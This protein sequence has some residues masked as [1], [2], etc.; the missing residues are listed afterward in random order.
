MVVRMAVRD[1]IDGCVVV[2]VMEVALK[3]SGVERVGNKL[4][5]LGCAVCVG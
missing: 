5:N 4:Y 3:E 1:E 2:A